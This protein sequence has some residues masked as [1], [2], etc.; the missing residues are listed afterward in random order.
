[1]HQIQDYLKEVE[2]L[3][4][5]NGVAKMYL[6][7]SA[8]GDKFNV[9]SDFDFLVTFK[10]IPISSYFDNYLS[11]KDNL[12]SL[13]GRDVDLLEEQTLKNPVLIKSINASKELIYG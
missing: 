13:L 2:K 10:P 11:F 12:K 5:Q 6:F 1:M 8:P 4:E 7:G 9:E 3:C